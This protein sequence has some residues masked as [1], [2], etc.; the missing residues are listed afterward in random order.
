M[1]RKNDIFSYNKIKFLNINTWE[2]VI[3]QINSLPKWR[4]IVFLCIFM[5]KKMSNG[6]SI[7]TEIINNHIHFQYL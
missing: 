4:L 2:Q 1:N 7:K 6:N 5:K 3:K